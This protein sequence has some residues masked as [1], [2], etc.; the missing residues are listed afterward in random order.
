[1]TLL[2]YLH[3]LTIKQTMLG[4]TMVGKGR[5]FDTLPYLVQAMYRN[6]HR[7][8]WLGYCPINV[9]IDL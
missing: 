7:E 2:N 8:N 5:P 6:L 3:N 1:M 9:V 4:K